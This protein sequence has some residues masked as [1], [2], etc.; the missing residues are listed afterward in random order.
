[1]PPSPQCLLLAL[2]VAPL[3][4][5]AQCQDPPTPP[6]GFPQGELLDQVV[7]FGDGAR[8]MVDVTFP[9]AQPSAC[10]WPL[11]VLV[12]GL[13]SSRKDLAW[14]RGNYARAGYVTVCYDV[15]GHGDLFG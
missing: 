10:G 13:G 9:S 4:L 11:L 8:T 2:L 14:A 5:H 3:A 7:T 12:H 15:R 1:M 6:Q